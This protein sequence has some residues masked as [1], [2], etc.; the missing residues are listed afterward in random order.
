LEDLDVDGSFILKCTLIKEDMRMC[1]GL[2]LLDH[3]AVGSF[4][5]ANET[6]ES[7]ESGKYLP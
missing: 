5:H 2:I 6:S 7:A 4:E 3:L 1:I